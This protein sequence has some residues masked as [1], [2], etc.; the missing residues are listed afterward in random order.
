MDNIDHNPS[1]TTATG[2]LHGTGISLFQHH[3]IDNHG[4]P[5]EPVP[6]IENASTKGITPLP[7]EYADV[8]PVQPWKSEPSFPETTFSASDLRDLRADASDQYQWLDHVKKKLEQDPPTGEDQDLHV[9][10][11]AFHA[12]RTIE[13]TDN[14]PD[15]SSLLPLFQK[16]AK[17]VAMILHAMNTINRSV[18]FLNQGQIPAI[19]DDH[20]LYALA[21]KIQWNWP[22]THGENKY[23]VMLGGLH[24]E[25][26][27]LRTLGDWLEGSGWTSVIIQANVAS[28]GMVDSF[29]KASHVSRTRHAHQITACSLN[30]L[31]SK[32]YEE[33]VQG[34][35]GED[36]KHEFYPWQEQKS[37]TC[38]EFK[39]WELTLK[40]Q[41]LILSFVKSLR[42]GRFD[43][44][45]ESIRQLL[46]RFFAL[47]H[48]NY[49]RWLTIYLHDMIRLADTCPTVEQMF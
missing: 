37:S 41:L 5:R 8:P 3:T 40:L 15:I 6:P 26:A 11:A 33:Y 9:S 29:L 14:P 13:A 36:Q 30:I 32:A 34:L 19:A 23:V 24:T 7:S 12:G 16:E 18:Q 43:L 28:A 21:K 25:M 27:A 17:S 20:P 42:E 31:M 47:D 44:Y 49:S 22:E 46:T 35:S 48:T 4:Q 45:L 2:S 10:W 38:P 1:S 39:Y